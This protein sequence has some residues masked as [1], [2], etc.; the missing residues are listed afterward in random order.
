MTYQAGVSPDEINIVVDVVLPS[1]ISE[2]KVR[3]EEQLW[4]RNGL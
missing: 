4:T 1:N 2:L 3:A